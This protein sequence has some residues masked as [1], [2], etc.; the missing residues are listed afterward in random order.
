MKPICD[1]SSL[2]LEVTTIAKFVQIFPRL[3]YKNPMKLHNKKR[4]GWMIQHIPAASIQLPF[5]GEN[6]KYKHP[7]FTIP[8][9]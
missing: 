9:I 1:F 8:P 4:S 2:K 6:R 5:P 3:I 7:I